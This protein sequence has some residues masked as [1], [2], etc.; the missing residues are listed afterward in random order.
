MLSIKSTYEHDHQ[1]VN[2]YVLHTHY[3]SSNKDLRG[4]GRSLSLD[5]F[6]DCPLLAVSI[7]R[8]RQSRGV[9]ESRRDAPVRRIFYCPEVSCTETSK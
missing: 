8:L 6:I 3:L 4:G 1:R 9:V 5:W 7:Y 2:L